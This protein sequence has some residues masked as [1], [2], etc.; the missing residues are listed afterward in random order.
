[1]MPD[2]LGHTT[3]GTT[4]TLQLTSSPSALTSGSLAGSQS[5]RFSNHALV[6]RAC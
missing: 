5:K 4:K 3:Y 2:A 6:G 1:M